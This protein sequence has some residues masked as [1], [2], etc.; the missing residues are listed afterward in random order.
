MPDIDLHIDGWERQN[1]GHLPELQSK[2][3]CAGGMNILPI[4][5]RQELSRKEAVKRVLV[6]GFRSSSQLVFAKSVF[7]MDASCSLNSN[8]NA[9]CAF[10]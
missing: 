10:L 4:F 5:S 6:I 3:E 9:C 7:P 8:A 2:L 1:L